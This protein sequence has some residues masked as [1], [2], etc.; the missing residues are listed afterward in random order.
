MFTLRTATVTTS[1]PDA[2]T[3]LFVSSKSLYFPVPTQRRDVNS[4]P[5]IMRLSFMPDILSLHLPLAPIIFAA[6]RILPTIY[7]LLPSSLLP[8][9]D[10]IHDLDCIV[11]FQPE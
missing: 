9:A 3:A 5:L 10:K 2:S 6:C 8:S 11:L 7:C 1:D 4:I